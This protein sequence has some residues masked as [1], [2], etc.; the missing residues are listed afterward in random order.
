[1]RG[2]TPCLPSGGPSGEGRF[3][4]PVM[5]TPE[6]CTPGKS[7]GEVLGGWTEDPGSGV[8]G[9]VGCGGRGDVARQGRGT[10]FFVGLMGSCPWSWPAIPGGPHACGPTLPRPP[11]ATPTPS[12]P[13]WGV[14]RQGPGCY[15]DGTPGQQGSAEPAESGGVGVAAWGGTLVPSPGALSSPARPRGGGAQSHPCQE[16]W[17][18]TGRGV[19][20]QGRQGPGVGPWGAVRSFSPQEAS[21]NP[22]STTAG[23][24]VGPASL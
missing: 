21:E 16:P 8:F 1:M 7:C 15:G 14:G 11:G 13:C 10:A 17:A 6:V 5:G 22:G 23:S 3:M 12:T 24:R 4:V 19:H 2:G 18:A 9:A 20:K